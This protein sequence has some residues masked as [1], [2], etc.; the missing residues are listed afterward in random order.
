MD[1]ENWRCWDKTP[2][3]IG[4]ATTT[5]FNAKIS[6][7]QNKVLDITGLVEKA[8]SDLEISDVEKKYFFTA[9][10]NKF[11]SETLDARIK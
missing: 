7:V 2:T 10:Y 3:T 1:K 9:D 4:L 11:T 5:V 6:W 8:V